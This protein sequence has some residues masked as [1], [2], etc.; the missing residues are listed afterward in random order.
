MK[1]NIYS[2]MC[3]IRHVAELGTRTKVD[4]KL[5]IRVGKMVGRIQTVSGN[6]VV[7]VGAS[8]CHI[9]YFSHARQDDV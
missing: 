1:H 2:L 5:E 4:E 9:H 3:L 8:S 7:V 6:F